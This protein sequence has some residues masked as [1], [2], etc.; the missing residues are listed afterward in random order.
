M[1]RLSDTLKS[2]LSLRKNS[3]LHNH[4]TFCDGKDSM[5]DMAKAA[6]DAGFTDYGFSSHGESYFD[7]NLKGVTPSNFLDY[8]RII[9]EL[10]DLYAGKMNIYTAIEQDYYSPVDIPRSELDY[11]IGSVHDIYS[12]ENNKGYWVDGSNEMLQS[13]IDEVF[14]SNSMKLVEHFYELSVINVRENSP[15]VIGHFDLIVKNNSNN[16]FF[17]ETSKN[18][19]NIATDALDECIKSDSIFE[20]NT[21]AV[22]RQF[23]TTPYPAPF[24]LKR[25]CEKKSPVILSA[26]AHAKEAVDFYFD[27]SKLL[28]K[29]IGFKSIYI[30]VD[31]KF[32]EQGI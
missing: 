9:G 6:F 27:K 2:N 31:G 19:I 1:N 21:G 28:L 10:K 4:S 12:T 7:P 29:N 32:I 13:C 18:Y 8:K 24:L 5:Y 26:D 11:L 30:F 25:L 14:G 3:S 15:D 23:R 22:Y 20:L 17:D 16:A